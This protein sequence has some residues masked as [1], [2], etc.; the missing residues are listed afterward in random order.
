M[1]KN[2]Q[3]TLLWANISLFP[4]LFTIVL[5]RYKGEIPGIWHQSTVAQIFAAVTLGW[6]ILISYFFSTQF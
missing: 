4:K 2:P 5:Q 3:G 1:Q 6:Q